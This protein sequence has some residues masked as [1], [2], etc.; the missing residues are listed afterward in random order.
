MVMKML[1]F[2]KQCCEPCVFLQ[3]RHGCD[4]TCWG[5]GPSGC[6]QTLLHRAIDE[7]NESTTCFLIRR[8]GKPKYLFKS[9]LFSET[10]GYSLVGQTLL[11]KAIRGSLSVK[12]A[13]RCDSFV[14]KGP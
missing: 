10:V 13:K 2:S 14:R 9:F 12:S 4:A 7:N 11:I 6:L 8:S 1:A 3:V 5:P